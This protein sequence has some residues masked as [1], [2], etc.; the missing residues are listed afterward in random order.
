LV[1]DRFCLV[2]TAVA[3]GCEVRGPVAEHAGLGF[4][5]LLRQL[6]DDAGLTQEELAEAARISQRAVSDLERGINRTARKDTALLL[7]GALGLDGP[8]R[9]LFVAAA[10]G[11]APAADVLTARH[12]TPQ[13]A[14]AA[15]ATRAHNLPVQLTSFIGRVAELGEVRAL[16]T[17]NRLVTLTGAGGAG[18]TRLALQVAAGML[19]EFP[20]GVWQVDL[21]PLTDP[22]LVSVAVAR[23]LGLPDQQGVPTMAMVTG[24][25]GA[26]RALVVLDNCEH[27]L[28]ACAVLAEDLLRACPGLVIVATSRE[29]VGV[30]GEATW[31]VPSLALAGDAIELFADRARRARPASR[32]PR[33]TLTRW[34]RSAAAW[35]GCRWRSNWRLP[36]CAPSRRRRS[37]PACTTGSGC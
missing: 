4:G 16:L 20:A 12:G 35:T 24:F 10:R 13:A 7:A 32:S 5:R 19:T 11:R 37:R 34:R 3:E 25:L 21:A 2:G 6:R 8:V 27:L 18:K 23:A 29:P 30:A 17:D 15:A 26:G 31:R 22:A 9:D 1:R 33:R 36:G 28:Q 14:F